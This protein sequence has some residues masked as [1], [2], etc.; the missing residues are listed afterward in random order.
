MENANN[1][2]ILQA[3]NIDER[4]GYP[5]HILNDTRLNDYYK[6]VS[7]YRVRPNKKISVFWVTGLK[8]LGRVSTNFF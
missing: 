5:D 7:L 3:V 1:M 6:R 4:I 2:Y 8:I